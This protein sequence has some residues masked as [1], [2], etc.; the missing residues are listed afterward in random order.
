PY[1]WRPMTFEHN[2]KTYLNERAIATQQT[3]WWMMGQIRDFLPDQVGGILW[4]G[5]DDAATSC[6]TPIYVCTTEVPESLLEGNGHMTQ[7]S[8]TAAFWI[9]NR[10]AQFAYLRYNT[11]YPDIK[12]AFDTHENNAIEHI[13]AIDKT[14]VELLKTS[15]SSA[16]D[17]LTSYSVQTA[18]DMF[19]KWC[20]LDRYLMV[21][22][23]DGNVKQEDE[24]GFIDNGFGKNIPVSPNTPGYSDNWKKAVADETGKK[25]ISK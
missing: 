13:K 22:Y 9:F 14:A 18:Q 5:V 20:N 12:E 19:N 10:V 2:G 23:I 21:K 17:Y 11:I 24:N 4:F 15:E 8:P 25:L 16:I 1:R 3:G 7:Y 6:L